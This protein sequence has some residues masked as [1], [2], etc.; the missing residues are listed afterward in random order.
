[1]SHARVFV[2]LTSKKITETYIRKIHFKRGVPV[3]VDEELARKLLT[4][5]QFTIVS[6]ADPL[7]VAINDAKPTLTDLGNDDLND[8]KVLL[9]RSGAIGDT[10][11]VIQVGK[12]LKEKYPRI[13]LTLAVRKK[14]LPLCNL[15]THFDSII[16]L[17][18]TVNFHFDYAV[19]FSGVIEDRPNDDTSYYKLHWERAG[20]SNFDKITTMPLCDIS[21]ANG[22]ESECKAL[23]ILQDAK[24]DDEPYVVVLAGTSS[25]L[26]TILPRIVKRICESLASD[27]SAKKKSQPRVHVL[28]LYGPQSVLIDGP[29]FS[30]DEKLP[31]VNS[32][33]E[34]I[35][36]VDNI[37]LDVSA[38]LTSKA[39]VV[40]GG[41]TGLLHFA[42]AVGRP[43]VSWWGCTNFN[44][45]IPHAP[46]PDR[47]EVIQP[48]SVDCAPCQKTRPAFCTRYD[49]KHA[50][51]MKAIKV[52]Q[53]VDAT[54]SLLEKFTP[55]Q[56]KQPR[57]PW[58][59]HKPEDAIK[60]Y[61]STKYN[62]A[63]LMGNC[64]S[65][66]GGGFHAWMLANN[67]ATKAACHVWIIAQSTSIAY[68]QD[69]FSSHNVTLITDKSNKLIRDDSTPIKFDLVVGTPHDSSILAVEY[70]KKHAKS[71]SA[72]LVYETPNFVK[73]YRSGRDSQDSFGTLFKQ[74]LIEADFIWPISDETKTHVKLWDAELRH[75]NMTIVS[76]I[77][78]TTVASEVLGTTC[79]D[80]KLTSVGRDDIAVIIARNI[81]YKKVRESVELIAE[82]FG[83]KYKFSSA[84]PLYIYLVGADMTRQLT[85]VRQEW[86]RKGIEVRAIENCT[87]INKW[88]LLRAAKCVIHLSEFEGFGLPVAEAMYA[89]VPVIANR[90][91]VLEES[92]GQHPYY[93]E[94]DI[95][96]IKALHHIWSAWDEPES[97]AGRSK[98]K[99]LGFTRDACSHVTRRFTVE[100]QRARISTILLQHLKEPIVQKQSEIISARGDTNAPRLAIVTPWGVRCGVAETTKLFTSGLSCSYRIFAPTELPDN[101]IRKD[102]AFVTRCW[103]RQF[104][105]YRE[106]LNAIVDYGAT[107]VHIQ[108]EFSLFRNSKKFLMLLRELRKLNIKIV[109][110]VHTILTSKFLADAGKLADIIIT[111]KEVPE[112]LPTGVVDFDTDI[113]EVQWPR[114][115]VNV[116]VIQLPVASVAPVS[117]DEAKAKLGLPLNGFVVGTA[118][119]WAPHKGIRELLD[120]FN[121][122]KLQCGK[123]V[124]YMII[125]YAPGKFPYYQESTRKHRK[126]IDRGEIHIHNNFY[127]EEDFLLRIS[128]CDVLVYYYDINSHISASAA[129]RYAMMI[130]K[131]I[132]CSDC[133]MFRE[134]IDEQEVL[135]IPFVSHKDDVSQ[136]LIDAIVRLHEEAP[137]RDTLVSN[138]KTFA[139]GCLPSK[140]AHE[141]EIVYNTVVG[142]RQNGKS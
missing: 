139:I 11:F 50:D 78:N 77:V 95:K 79:M 140:V 19:D 90:L 81:G 25:P 32:K 142:D 54:Y 114:E 102:E 65:Y 124:H 27:K 93:A 62:I 100:Q 38:I 15:F 91:P 31:R 46:Y 138:S 16:K 40:I 6:N 10:L 119:M 97:D 110:T 129:I 53:V 141:H 29:I 22:S 74:A 49:G 39:A 83:M 75:K 69:S 126:A 30:A 128:A 26:K 85:H 45:T 56:N 127:P 34:W 64:N 59:I 99:L 18:D 55:T 120:T 51:C 132:I 36:E 43:T 3:E 137:L 106:L 116:K 82:R 80:D 108:H 109:I 17:E 8:R 41:D 125:G 4:R 12:Y 122:V 104:L 117:K 118:G 135:K 24:I 44:H 57:T 76:P 13:N 42:N 73:Q 131:P 48:T 21:N 121:D 60:Y 63:F 96:V 71:K 72:C 33:S 115:K 105:R 52:A 107:V 47:C 35:Y 58:V 87:E 92:F 84:R 136:P 130:G 7:V 86:K 37:P 101:I 88:K 23:Q 112:M 134:F 89:G 66:N 28:C 61:D 103:T 70:A 14:Y 67:F 20:L 2:C 113:S 94:T 123:G 68:T 111:P 133:M 5:G 98:A 9:R 1:M